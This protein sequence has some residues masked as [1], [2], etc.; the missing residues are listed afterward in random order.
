MQWLFCLTSQNCFLQT[1]M[2]LP[3]SM[4]TVYLQ[5]I[6]GP[7]ECFHEI[8]SSKLGRFR[9]QIKNLGGPFYIPIACTIG[10]SCPIIFF[11]RGYLSI[12]R[13]GLEKEFHKSLC[14]AQ[15]SAFPTFTFDT[16]SFIRF[17]IIHH[18]PPFLILLDKQH[19]DRV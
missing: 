10:L 16:F 15:K 4:I 1:S 11:E 12:S 13:T 5:N 3:P 2:Y 14:G 8:Q 19:P 17:F 6:E 9:L 7:E 18:Y